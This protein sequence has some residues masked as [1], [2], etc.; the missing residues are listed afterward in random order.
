MKRISNTI[1][2]RVEALEQKRGALANRPVMLVPRL[3]SCDEWEATA[4]IQ[5]E[6]LKANVKT[7]EAP[8]Y[9]GLPRL[10]LVPQHE[11]MRPT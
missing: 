8:D 10:R 1:L 5:Q 7:H 9:S 2:R 6:I 4:A 3:M 11:L